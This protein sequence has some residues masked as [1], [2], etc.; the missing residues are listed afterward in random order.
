MLVQYMRGDVYRTEYRAIYLG[1][2]VTI[3]PIII[4]YLIFSRYI[5]NGIAIGAVKE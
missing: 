1:L 2:A 3:V 5:V 4:I